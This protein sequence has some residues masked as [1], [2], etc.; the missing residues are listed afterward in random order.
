[1]NNS[2]LFDA[3]VVDLELVLAQTAPTA[4]EGAT[5]TI[6]AAAFIAQ[7]MFLSPS[8]KTQKSYRP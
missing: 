8:K 4:C 5:P 7:A 2:E 1:L 3:V 6:I